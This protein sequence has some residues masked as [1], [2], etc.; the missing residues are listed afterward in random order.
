[1]DSNF[2]PAGPEAVLVEAAGL[3][4]AAQP[5]V[6]WKRYK[7]VGTRIGKGSYGSVSVAWDT[8]AEALVA[9]KKQPRKSETARRELLFLSLCQHP[10]TMSLRDSFVDGDFLFLVTQYMHFDLR[11]AWERA[12]RH[13]DFDQ[14]RAW[15]QQAL[16]GT[17]HL[18]Q[19]G[20][21]HGDFCMSNLLIDARGNG[22]KIADLGMAAPACR[23]VLK[24]PMYKL[25]YRAPEI[26][27]SLWP[28]ITRT[29]NME[30]TDLWALGVI[31][32]ALF[33]GSFPFLGRPEHSPEVQKHWE[34]DDEASWQALWQAQTTAL[35]SPLRQWADAKKMPGWDRL[36]AAAGSE[37][38]TSREDHGSSCF[39]C[40]TILIVVVVCHSQR[41]QRK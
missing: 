22:L 21:A 5:A 8:H 3:S 39:L 16:L 37:S 9:L 34:N 41:K 20:Y 19:C 38:L 35:G 31:I 6:G 23:L 7:A 18:H 4:A 24:D 15:S 29:I 2:A 28:G 32:A 11:F 14:V 17:G 40:L 36:T 25:P 27:L 13:L 1:M 10:N 33:T 30:F 26:L 12:G